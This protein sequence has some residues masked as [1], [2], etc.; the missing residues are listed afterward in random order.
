MIVFSL[1]GCEETYESFYLNN[2]KP[3]EVE[4]IHL[5]SV[6]LSGNANQLH[7]TLKNY[8]ELYDN[9]YTKMIRAGDKDHLSDPN[10]IDSFTIPILQ[11]F[12]NDSSMQKIF[13][14]MAS[15]FDDFEKYKNRIG[16]GMGN[17]SALFD[18]GITKAKI[19]TFYSNFNATVLENDHIIWIGLDMY[20]GNDNEIVKML[21][22]STFPNYYKQKMDEKYIISD[23]FFSFLMTHHYQPI[24]DELLA[25]MLSY[26][27][28]AYLMDIILPFENEENKFRYS[29]DEL[30]WC[31]ENEEYI[32]R[33]IVDEK[34]LYNTEPSLVDPFFQEG[35][36]T[37]SFG[38]DSPS[39]IGIWLG[40]EM[41]KDFVEKNE[42]EIK[43][44][45]KENDIQ[46]LL[47][48]YE[49][50]E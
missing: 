12:L 36:Y 16:V 31:K 25:R 2:S 5:H 34:L 3:V 37:K 29:A 46:K 47:K 26:G 45:I 32:W 35:P 27:K 13:K 48:H 22:P 19:G 1:L 41:I 24:G 23:V 18:A 49:P 44:L 20:L 21:P 30:E 8:P 40:Y 42:I 9:F 7:D 10:K 33:F 43:D 11:H 28:I 4:C 39:T 15:S 17:Y 50:R 6:F 38:S 14:N